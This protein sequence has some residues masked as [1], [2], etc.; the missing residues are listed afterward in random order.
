MAISTS[1]ISKL[2]KQHGIGQPSIRPG[3]DAFRDRL[4]ASRTQIKS[5]AN[6]PSLADF[7][8]ESW[9]V[10]EGGGEADWN[11]H[12]EAVAHH[13]EQLFIDWLRK[14]ENP[15]YVQRTQKLL[16][17]V[18]PGSAKSRI[19]SVCFPAWAWLHCPMWRSICLSSNPRVAIR[20]SLYCRDL[21]ESDWYQERFSPGWRLRYDQNTKSLF[22]NTA[23]GWRQALGWGSRVTGSRA[24]CL[25]ADDPHDADEASSD[26]KRQAVIDR[27]DNSIGNRVNDMRS[28]IWLGI[29]QRLKENDWGG[30]VRKEGWSLLSIPQEYEGDDQPTV[31]GWSD[32]RSTIGELMF[33]KR[34]PASVVASEKMRLGM[35]YS[36][37]HQ[38]RPTAA[39]GGMFKLRNWHLYNPRSLPK[40]RRTVL[41]LDCSFKGKKN[42]DYNALAVISETVDF[43]EI[44]SPRTYIDSNQI[45]Q[46]HKER[47]PGY[48]IRDLWHEKA[49]ITGVETALHQVAKDYPEAVTKLLEDKAN[50]PA[51]IDRLKHSI[52]GMVAINPGKSSKEERAASIQP[53]QERH[54]I[55]IPLAPQYCAVLEG[56]GLDTLTLDHWWDIFPPERSTDAEHAPVEQWVKDLLNEFTKFPNAANDDIVDA[57]DQAIIW[58]QGNVG[59]GLLPTARSETRS[60]AD[61]NKARRSARRE[62]PRRVDR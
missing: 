27:W 18:P 9:H 33:P 61:R 39:G 3:Y 51:I 44:I 25:L 49:N 11:W 48:Y 54:D 28:S 22:S 21:I 38:Q 16:I 29:M 41:S 62:R 7:V 34:F 30:H 19:V 55:Y 52:A 32:P 46:H 56:M 23:G 35:G 8:R 13:C 37:Q 17:N 31:Y 24:D 12:M 58:M 43:R 40:F 10:L 15:N 4:I 42:S 45:E 50:G 59:Q 60:P 6:I 14:R 26:A 1:V 36:G 47:A 2:A 5:I 57:V 20:D 53:I